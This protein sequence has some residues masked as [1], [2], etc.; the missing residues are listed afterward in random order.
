MVVRDD[1]V[2][3]PADDWRVNAGPSLLVLALLLALAGEFAAFAAPTPPAHQCSDPC[4]QAARSARNDCVSSATGA[5]TDASGACLDRDVRCVEACR[6][7]LQECRDGTGLGARLVACDLEERRAKDRCRDRFPPGSRRREPCISRTEVASFQCRRN[8]FREFRQALASCRSAFGQCADACAPGG[9][10]GGID[11]C[12]SDAKAALKD[13][14]SS[15]RV[16]YRATASGCVNK[17]VGCV[18]TCADARDT[19]SAPT[20]ATFVAASMACTAAENAAAAAC[21]AANPAGSA[22]L[23]QCLMTAQANAFTCRE[24][25]LQAAGPGFAACTQTYIGCVAAC[26]KA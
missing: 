22:A 19:C 20:Q 1:R 13:D 11:S 5:F 3:Q 7:Q 10:P 2:R 6:F 18:Q 21:A 16:T 8:V 23:Q 15:C 24:A 17:D 9:P 26:P 12:K 25:A 4:L 14:V